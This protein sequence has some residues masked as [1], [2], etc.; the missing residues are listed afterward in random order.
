[1]TGIPTAV[2]SKV[3]GCSDPAFAACFQSLAPRPHLIFHRRDRIPF[4]IHEPRQHA[5]RRDRRLVHGDPA[6]VGEHRRPDRVA[7]Y[8]LFAAAELRFGAGDRQKR[9]RIVRTDGRPAS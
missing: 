1:M 4:G 9:V 5:H 3:P 6:A 2:R 7:R 8:N